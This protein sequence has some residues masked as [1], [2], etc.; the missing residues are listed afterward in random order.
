[1]S[2]I[3][4]GLKLLKAVSRLPPRTGM[5]IGTALGLLLHA[6]ARR[7]RAV[8][9][10]NLA[11]CFPDLTPAALKQR[12]RAAM[13]EHGRGLIETGWA[14]FR[15]VDFVSDR[16][17]V[18]GAEILHQASA[19]GQGVLLLCP[20]YSMLDLVAPL[21]HQVVGRFVVTYRPNDTP[22]FD[23]AVCAGRLRY[24][25]LVPVR[26]IREMARQ[27]QSGSVVWFGPD[28][29]MGT[30]G[31]VFAP[32][33]GQPAATVTTPARLTR[34]TG[35][36]PVFLALHRDQDGLYQLAFEVLPDYP[37]ADEVHNAQALNAAIE[38]ALTAHPEQ[39][40]WTHKRFK[41]Q[42]NL[43]SQALYS[44]C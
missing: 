43:P 40:L 16:M 26:A 14:W 28:Q 17:Q 18:Q 42:P 10:V 32:F 35:A 22:A 44:D 30:R 4:F 31:A 24:A 9:A 1:M 21:V 11:L 29:D 8:C 19:R 7:R 37:D 13:I 39:Y 12:V 38:R 20:H 3:D 27:L 2:L 33:F 5:A 25:D 6:T 15:P 41:T 34:M 23:R 36:L